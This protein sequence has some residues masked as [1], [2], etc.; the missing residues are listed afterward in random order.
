MPKY[1]FSTVCNNYSSTYQVKMLLLKRIKPLYFFVSFAVGLLVV[2][3]FTPPP[4]VVVK[5]PSPYNAGSV[6]YN[7][8]SNSCFVYK[9]DKVA[10]PRDK[11]LIKDQPVQI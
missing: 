4:Q 6:I 2:Y 7:D 5:F 1:Y 8:D 3:M 10:C 11:T 9:A